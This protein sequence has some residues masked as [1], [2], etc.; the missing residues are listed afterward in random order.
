MAGFPGISVRGSPAFFLYSWR[1]FLLLCAIMRRFALIDIGSLRI[2]EEVKGGK[3][4]HLVRHMRRSRALPS[5]LLVD[6]QSNVILDGHHRFHACR[7]LGCKRV[8]CILVD[9]LQD[10]SITVEPR[11]PGFLVTK[12]EV[13]R[14]GMAGE[15][16]PPKT[17]KHV[18]AVKEMGWKVP[19]GRLL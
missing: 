8:A 13:V 15:P 11:K 5:P 10:P 18:H 14:R 19:L 7:E 12:E 1:R 4:G 17:S 16:Y 3:A 9:Y 6:A 2:H